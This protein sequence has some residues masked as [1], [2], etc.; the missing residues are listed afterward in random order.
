MNI[1]AK[2][3]CTFAA[4]G[5]AALVAAPPA[6]AL[7]TQECSAK[8][9]AAKA[10]GTLGGQKWND[11][12]KAQCGADAAAAPAAAPAAAAPAAPAAP[13]EV[14]KEAKKEAAP[15]ATSAAPAGPAVFPSAVDPKYSKETAGKAR[16]HTCVDQYNA[17]KATNGNGGL[18]WIQKGGGYY[19]ECTKKLK[20]SA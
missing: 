19:S 2:L 15:A 9:Q 5:F 11:F 16:M 13:K 6:Q 14:K 8:Y 4:T 10:A 7:T 3:F 12:R 20:G 17:N 18:K 1:Q